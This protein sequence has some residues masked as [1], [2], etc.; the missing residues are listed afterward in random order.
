MRR[1]PPVIESSRSMASAPCS[2]A[3]DASTRTRSSSIAASCWR[4]CHNGAEPADRTGSR[5]GTLMASLLAACAFFVGIHVFISGSS[6]R[7]AI[8]ERIGERAYL[9][10][11]SLLSLA[12]IVWLVWAYSRAD[13]VWLWSPPL[14]LR[15]AAPV[16]VLIAFLFV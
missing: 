14:A 3:A 11:F 12:G 8:V 13:G 16:L 15:W 1:S 10:V 9:G 5:E 2:C 4:R 7:G 6:L